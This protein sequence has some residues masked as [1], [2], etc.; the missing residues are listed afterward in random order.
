MI[1]WAVV[2]WAFFSKSQSKLIPYILPVFPPLAVVI[3]AWLA[4]VPAGPK[5]RII[6]VGIWVF[7]GIAVLLAAG[8]LVA[9]SVPRVLNNAPLIAML[10]DNAICGA[11]AL[12]AGAVA[13]PWFHRR[14][15]ARAALVSLALATVGLF[16]ALAHAQD[17][18]A[19][20]GTKELA[21]QVKAQAKPGDRVMHYHDFF[22]DFTFYAER[23][24]DVVGYYGELEVKEDVTP[25][26]KERFIDDAEFRRQWDG[27]GRIWVVARKEA[28]TE[29]FAD[30]TFHYHL[31]GEGRGHY[32]FS[33]RP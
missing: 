33:N 28:A 32:L 30:P 25:G 6:G 17:E 19:R 2:V 26:V 22:H 12:V 29:L 11:L 1:V 9:V 24:V 16:L 7:S 27:A 20:P 5:P 10:R 8:M 21:M 4:R 3:G 13:A 14:G 31:L 15:R 18:I 23:I